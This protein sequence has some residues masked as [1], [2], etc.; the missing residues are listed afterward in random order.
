MERRRVTEAQ[1]WDLVDRNVPREWRVTE[2][3]YFYANVT[4][5]TA[6]EALSK[7][8]KW[9]EEDAAVYALSNQFDIEVR[10]LA[11]AEY[12]RMRLSLP[13]NGR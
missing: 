8:A 12:A 9:L 5:S 6:R 11:T 10:C 7:A 1:A 3:G 4:A 13:Q 2:R